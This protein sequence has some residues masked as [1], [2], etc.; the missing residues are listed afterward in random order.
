[1]LLQRHYFIFFMANIPLCIYIYHI[2]F[3]YSS[4]DGHFGHLHVLA[5]VNGAAMNIGLHVSFWTM[6]FS[7]YVILPLLNSV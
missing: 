5:I 6:F 7:G 1:M 2:F 4:V 3:N